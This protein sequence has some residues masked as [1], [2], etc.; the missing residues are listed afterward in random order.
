MTNGELPQPP[1]RLSDLQQD[2]DDARA[3]DDPRA[4]AGQTAARR[5][6]STGN[7]EAKGASEALR[8]LRGPGAAAV[9]D[10]AGRNGARAGAKS[11]ADVVAD[12]VLEVAAAPPDD[13]DN[14]ESVAVRRPLPPLS[15]AKR[16]ALERSLRRPKDVE[17][18]GAEGAIN[19]LICSDLKAQ[20]GRDT[21][22][23]M[24]DYVT[25]DHDLLGL[26]AKRDTPLKVL[27]TQTFEFP[28]ELFGRVSGDLFAL[29]A[30][31]GAVGGGVR[32]AAL[33]RL[34]KLAFQPQQVWAS[35]EADLAAELGE[36]PAR[37]G[38]ARRDRGQAAE[39]RGRQA[40]RAAQEEKEEGDDGAAPMRG[41][42]GPADKTRGVD[43]PHKYNCM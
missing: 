13:D 37:R 25:E 26:T 4:A 7:L 22:E 12:T 33:G 40:G 38:A 31:A 10:V 14:E 27:G 3:V 36:A 29:D 18:A 17:R 21:A 41:A 20:F 2:P 32:A 34:S 39:A 30:C 23:A 43:Q 6:S 35:L 15:D 11:D 9:D 28:A 8:A 5:R 19:D 16:A 24:A 1:R 42:P